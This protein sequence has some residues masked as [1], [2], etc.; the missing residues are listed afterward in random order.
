MNITGARIGDGMTLNFGVLNAH[1]RDTTTTYGLMNLLVK[2][3]VWVS[4][5]EGCC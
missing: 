4:P 2:P 5:R 1:A 3:M